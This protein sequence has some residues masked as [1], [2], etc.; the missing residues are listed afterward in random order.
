MARRRTK[1][2]KKCKKCNRKAKKTR[3][4]LRGGDYRL[5][6]NQT[7][8]G[9][10]LGPN[11]VYATASGILGLDQYNEMQRRKESGQRE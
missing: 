6:T 2:C 1:K 5:Y 7:L 3:R 4:R 9:M 10:P 11:A 8:L